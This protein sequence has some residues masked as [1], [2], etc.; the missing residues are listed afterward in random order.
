MRSAGAGT[1]RPT[2]PTSSAEAQVD[3]DEVAAYSRVCGFRLRGDLPPTYPHVLAFPL[4]MTLMT[5]RSFPFKLMGLV[6]LANRIEQ[7]VADRDR[8]VAHAAGLGREPPRPP[9]RAADR[10][11]ERGAGRRRARLERTEHLPQP[12]RRRGVEARR[13]APIR[14]R[15]SSHPRTG[16]SPATSAGATRRVSGDRNPIHLHSLSARLL[17]FPSAIAHGMWTYARALSSLESRLPPE[18]VSRVE[19]RA[20]LRIPGKAAS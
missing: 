4:A 19:F 3:P 14:S 15:A 13:P 5:E 11:R 12:R 16:T 20:P 1:R 7:R 8:R 9:P 18:H 10:R 6:H 17:G 2:T